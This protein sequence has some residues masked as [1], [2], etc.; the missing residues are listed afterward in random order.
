M[1]EY[2]HFYNFSENPFKVNPDP[3]FFFISESNREALACIIYGIR[4]RKGV[5]W[6]SGEAGI[7]KTSLI[8]YLSENLEGEMPV[9]VIDQPYI[10]IKQ[11]L[12]KILH[13]FGAA[14][15]SQEKAFLIKQLDKYLT[16]EINP[17]ENLAIL[18][19]DVHNLNKETMDELRLLSN[20]ATNRSKLFQLV[21]FGRPEIE[22]KLN[23]EDL[24]AL[25]QR[26][27][28]RSEISRL[29]EKESLQYIEHHLRLVGGSSPAVFTLEAIS[30][31]CRQAKGIPRFINSVCDKAFT[32]GYH[33][34]SERIDSL[35]VREALSRMHKE[36]KYSGVWAFG[37]RL[38]T[39]EIPDAV[40]GVLR[41]VYGERKR[42][43]GVWTPGGNFLSK[44]VPYFALVIICLGAGI[45]M[46]KDLI[47]DISEK[48]VAH[49]IVP[50]KAVTPIIEREVAEPA[51][52]SRPPSPEKIEVKPSSKRL[53]VTE[54]AVAP[55]RGKNT[56]IFTRNSQPQDLKRKKSMPEPPSATEE[57][58]A[59]IEK[60]IKPPPLTKSASDSKK[61]APPS[62]PS[63]LMESRKKEPQTQGVEKA[64]QEGPTIIRA[65]ASKKIRPGDIWKIYLKA[66][67][68]NGGMKY[69][70]ST[71]ER[72]GS[73]L[74]IIILQEEN[75]EHFSGYIYLNTFGMSNSPGLMT[76]T[77]TIWIKDAAGHL[78]QPMVF[79]LDFH[80]NIIQ[81]KPPKGLFKEQEL[82]PIM[83][84]LQRMTDTGG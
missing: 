83:V 25:K 10:S 35:I 14:P 7:G 27:M 46:G 50:E 33:H 82:G 61:I 73:H 21:L 39:R 57:A 38:V 52:K 40:R 11:L 48:R 13:Q 63:P 80:N 84:Q 5:I 62:L 43:F 3:R 42:F 28:I 67:H 32:V 18:V 49:L 16:E 79:P 29:T 44:S 70:F 55:A 26:I 59:R 36:G 64:S 53:T 45:F 68:P 19:D 47:R 17:D 56:K 78:S 6:V 1:N 12:T 30:L 54:K 74:S 37:G 65:F 22:R 24:K 69:I 72:A 51:S 31:I 66:S 75:R 9:V 76:L 34:S 23:S 2:T 4:E 8:Q 71:I 41:Q 81:E 60:E 20:L 15:K 58:I 77:L